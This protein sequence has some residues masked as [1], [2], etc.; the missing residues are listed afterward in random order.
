MNL[1]G[2]EWRPIGCQAIIGHRSF[3]DD[4]ILLMN[5]SGNRP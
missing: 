4:R 1:Y 3:L 2:F 5:L